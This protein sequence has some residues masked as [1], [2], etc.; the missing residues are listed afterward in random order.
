MRRVRAS[1]V[2]DKADKI[3]DVL[4]LPEVLYIVLLALFVAN[5]AGPFSLDAMLRDFL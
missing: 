4:Y 5:G 1:G 3:D 2:I